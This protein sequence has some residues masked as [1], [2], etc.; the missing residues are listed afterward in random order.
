[1]M[2]R[3]SQEVVLAAVKSLGQQTLQLVCGVS[4]NS[5]CTS[6]ILCHPRKGAFALQFASPSLLRDRLFVLAAVQCNGSTV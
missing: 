6:C 2:F 5:L 1:M 4:P 3:A